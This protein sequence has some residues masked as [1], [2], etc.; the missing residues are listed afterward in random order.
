M[1][2][3]FT[4]TDFFDEGLDSIRFVIGVKYFQKDQWSSDRF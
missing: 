2:E 1:W 3:I 4:F